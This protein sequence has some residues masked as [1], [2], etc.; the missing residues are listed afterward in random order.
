MKIL[1]AGAS[2]FIG[3]NI[4]SALL[5][6]GHQVISVSRRHGVDFGRMQETAD[7]LP[8]LTGVDAVINCV[9]IIGETRGQSFTGLHTV[10]PQ[11]LFDACAQCG[12]RRVVQI[13]ALGADETAFS[14]YHLSKR[15][16]DDYLRRLDLDW[17]VLRPSLIYGRGGKSAE[18]FMR[19]ASL[20]LL[21][22]IGDGQQ[23][24]QPVFVGD[25]VEA[26]LLCLASAETKLTLD[27]VGSETIT[28]AE[29]LQK[30]RRAQGRPRV[31][32]LHIPYALALLFAFLGRRFNPILQPDNL[33]MLKKGYWAD[34][35]AFR[36]FLGR[37]PLV[38]E[39]ALFFRDIAPLA[40]V[41]CSS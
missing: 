17:F 29:W 7:W 16:A 41:G 23:K 2:G 37:T 36:Q 14:A 6:R 32:L 9:G 18:L 34:G 8:Y 30:M 19:L 13:S 38:A 20:P 28:F 3:R 25:V 31:P 39:P 10:A 24:L 33:R 21:P 4:A 5:A 27:L 40:S 12:V 15:A 35:Q 11:A 22:V 26:V 1:L